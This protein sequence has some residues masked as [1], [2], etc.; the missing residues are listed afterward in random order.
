MTYYSIVPRLDSEDFKQLK[1]SEIQGHSSPRLDIQL[2]RRGWKEEKL[3]C[4]REISWPSATQG[5]GKVLIRHPRDYSLS[6]DGNHNLEK[7]NHWSM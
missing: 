3:G 2:L 6:D 1:P 4:R 7:S 5:R